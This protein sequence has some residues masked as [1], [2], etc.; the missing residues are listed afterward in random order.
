MPSGVPPKRG[1]GR[2]SRTSPTCPPS[3]S[4]TEPLCTTC[5]SRCTSSGARALA[6]MRPRLSRKRPR[7]AALGRPLFWKTSPRRVRSCVYVVTSGSS[8][9]SGANFCASSGRMGL[10]TTT[11]ASAVGNM[12]KTSATLSPFWTRSGSTKVLLLMPSGQLNSRP[13]SIMDT[14]MCWPILSALRSRAKRAAHTDLDTTCGVSLSKTSVPRTSDGRPASS[15]FRAAM[16]HWAWAMPS[17]TGYS[18]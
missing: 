4:Q 7:S 17:K 15:L 14:S 16:P 2:A 12:V 3:R 1:A 8:R 10:R 9:T 18:L 13:T 11:L 5:L 6:A